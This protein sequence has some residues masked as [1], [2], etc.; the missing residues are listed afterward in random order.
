MLGFVYALAVA[1]M[2]FASR[3]AIRALVIGAETFSRFSMA[4]IVN[5]CPVR[6]GAGRRAR[7]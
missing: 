3:E 4:R 1:V 6:D 7:S 5:L 2:F